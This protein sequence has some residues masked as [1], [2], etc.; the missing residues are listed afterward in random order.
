MI[1]ASEEDKRRQIEGLAE[2][3]ARHADH[4]DGALR[5]LR[6]VALSGGNV[7][8]ELMETVKVCSLG[9]ITSA[10][11]DVGGQYRRNM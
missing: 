2:F 11:F 7:F 1:R 9:Q 3:H 4:S 5:R 8:G 10:L 6:E